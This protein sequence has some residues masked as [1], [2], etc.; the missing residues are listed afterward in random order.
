MPLERMQ[1]APSN[2]LNAQLNVTV[3]QTVTDKARYRAAP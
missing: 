2:D 3:G 1:L